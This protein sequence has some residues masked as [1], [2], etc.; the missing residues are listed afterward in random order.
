MSE[1]WKDRLQRIIA[2]R[3]LD[4]KELSRLSQL[5]ETAVRDLL[6]RQKNKDGGNIKTLAQ[7]ARAPLGELHD[8]VDPH[9]QNVQI[10]GA[11]GAQ[12]AWTPYERDFEMLRL[13]V[14][15]GQ[16]VALRVVG[17]AL[18]PVY[19]DGDVIMG[20]RHAGP[21]ADNLIGLECIVQTD[22][23]ERFVKFLARGLTPGRFNL[24]SHNP[25]EKDVENV[26]IA[27]AAP[28]AWIRRSQR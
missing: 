15:G 27:W 23:G 25:T 16:P 13:R 28:V 4:M 20:V 7:I 8:G 3:K 24:R 5:G 1:H 22:D 12:G 17:D 6:K 18:T 26:R 11:L 14:E 2:E 21:A 9:I 10:I 19:R